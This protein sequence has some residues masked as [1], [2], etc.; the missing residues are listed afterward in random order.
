MKSKSV[1][2]TLFLPKSDET[3]GWESFCELCSEFKDSDQIKELF[4]LI[5]TT[6]EKFALSMRYQLVKEL[7][8]GELS[9]R[10]IA[11]KLNVSISKI[12]RG[13]N[14]LKLHSAEFKKKL[15]LEMQKIHK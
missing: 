11:K 10:D 8:L 1:T 4:E 12:T 2:D 6:E 9:Q 5:L 3:Q 15:L 7:L 13:S 14:Q